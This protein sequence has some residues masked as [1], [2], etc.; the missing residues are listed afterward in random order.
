MNR[1][2]ESVVIIGR[3]SQAWIVAAALQRSLGATGV[4]I[5]VIELPSTLQPVDVYTAI[6]SLRGLH[7]QIGLSE[8]RV[9]SAARAVPL[10]AQRY[11]NWAG[12]APPFMLGYDDPAPP[13]FGIGLAS[14]WVKARQ[15][16]SR[17]EFEDFLLGASAAK[18]ARVPMSVP[19]EALHHDLSAGYGYTLDARGY[20]VLLK[21][22]AEHLGVQLEQAILSDVEL[23]QE[24]IAAVM[25]S[26]GE[27][28]EADLFVDASGTE[29]ALISRFDGNA[30]E[31]FGSSWP[32]DR[33]VVASGPP[34]NPAPAYSHI[35][36][37]NAGW[38][39]LYPTQNRTT[40]IAVYNSRFMSDAEMSTALPLL[41]RMPLQGDA[42]V[43]SVR[44]GIRR[45]PWVGNCVAVGEAA[46]SHDPIDS[47]GLHGLHSCVSHLMALFPAEAGVFPEAKLFNRTITRVAQN[48][49]DYQLTHYRLNRRFDEPFWDGCRE[50]DLPESLQRKIDVFSRRAQVPMYDN[51]VFE[52]QNWAA[53][54]I[55]AGIIPEMYDP[56]VDMLPDEAQ[57]AEMRERLRGIAAAVQEMPSVPQFLSN[58]Q[59]AA[60][61]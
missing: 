11:S 53:L 2:V 48:L 32:C 43:S 5:R 23:E 36:A 35:S 1:R 61:G 14:Y 10:V 40:A 39:G 28:V 17:V 38:V 29:G 59:L 9:L 15:E 6:P 12:A 56:R 20:T 51:D 3:D 24:R 60:A 4:R 50:L 21:K 46:F 44:P 58:H 49:H 26:S 13:G 16:G 55:G 41:A 34:I 8:E 45:S 42:V 27:R 52:E 30:L 47:F 31:S 22:F 25:L 33:M 57:I 18:R 7:R 37:F 54:F 19:H